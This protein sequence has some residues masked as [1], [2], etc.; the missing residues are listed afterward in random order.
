[1]ENYLRKLIKGHSRVIVPNLGAF[2]ASQEK[3]SSIIFN[4]FLSFND[5]FLIGHISNEEGID[6]VIAAQKVE[7]F[8]KRVKDSL[9]ESGYF[10]IDELGT[11]SKG[12]DGTLQFRQESSKVSSAEYSDDELLDVGPTID[13]STIEIDE[14]IYIPPLQP[15]DTIFAID[16]SNQQKENSEKLNTLSNT[17]KPMEEHNETQPAAEPEKKR[18][19]L[20]W[21]PILLL[22]I[23]IICAIA[24]FLLYG[25]NTFKFFKGKNIV[26]EQPIETT[27]PLVEIPIGV[28]TPDNTPVQETPVAVEKPTVTATQSV[29]SGVQ[30]HIILGSFK[31][32]WRA[33]KLME[34][35]KEQGY[36]QTAVFERNSRF[37]VT[38]ECHSSVGQALRRQEKLLDELKMESWVLSLRK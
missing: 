27:T 3:D 22:S 35:L 9:E 11:L 7:E 13:T 17:D 24:Y 20:F 38:V 1:M 30:H 15:D 12:I 34:K 14:P 31:D 18:K 23:V 33:T 16:T 19:S 26:V 4:G 36:N 2:I 21:L 6:T 10:K 29:V 28:A 8:V 25:D 32:E 5:G 37:L